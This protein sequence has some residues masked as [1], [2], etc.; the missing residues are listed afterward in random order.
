[1]TTEL[2]TWL[3][4]QREARGWSRNDMAR[5]LIAAARDAGDHSVPDFDTVAGYIPRWERG[6]VRLSERYRICYCRAFG[7]EASRFGPQPGPAGGAAT[8]RPPEG[9][10]DQP[11]VTSRDLS[12]TVRQTVL[13]PGSPT[14][15]ERS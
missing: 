1:M 3:R 5:R 10:Q 4:E 7:I 11:H 8:S 9:I 2:G 15:G 12:P 6:Q 13:E 14:F